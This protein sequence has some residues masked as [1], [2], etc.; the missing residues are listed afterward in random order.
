MLS[1]KKVA[2]LKEEINR[3]IKWA[4]EELESIER[5][6]PAEEYSAD[7][8]LQELS[9]QINRR[10]GGLSFLLEFIDKLENGFPE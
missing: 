2:L 10:I 3:Q 9:Y 8:L 6:R 7:F 5:A 1:N 4:S